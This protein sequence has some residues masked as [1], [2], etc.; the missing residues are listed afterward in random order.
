MESSLVLVIIPVHNGEI[1]IKRTV[2]NILAQKNVNLELLLINNNSVDNSLD[3]CVDLQKQDKRIRVYDHDE[4]GTSLARKRGIEESKGDYIVFSDQDDLFVDNMAI[5][6]MLEI[7]VKD[8]VDIVQ[9]NHINSILG[10]KRKKRGNVQEKVYLKEEMKEHVMRGIFGS[11]DVPFNTPV[12]NK[13]YRS[14]CLK[15][16]IKDINISLYY[17]EDQFLNILAFSYANAVSVNNGAYYCWEIGGFSSSGKVVFALFDDYEKIRPIE[18]EYVNK[19]YRDT[20]I[21]YNL[22]ME[23][24]YLIRNAIINMIRESSPSNEIIDIIK[25]LNEYEFVKEAKSF[26]NDNRQYMYDELDCLINYKTEKEYYEYVKNNIPK[27]NFKIKIIK[28]V[29]ILLNIWKR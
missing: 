28:C 19:Y 21:K 18:F 17:A 27:E 16:I 11:N 3:I 25:K 7:I 6:N 13:I 10:I 4:K 12:W 15:S 2:K 29:N 26:F 8:N 23:A 14:S 5:H 1:K 22:C 20:N 9:F 24:I